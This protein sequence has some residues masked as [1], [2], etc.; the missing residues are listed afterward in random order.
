MVNDD[1]RVL[2]S[3]SFLSMIMYAEDKCPRFFQ[4]LGKCYGNK[5][6]DKAAVF[7]LIGYGNLFVSTYRYFIV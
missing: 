5:I 3:V 6:I 7:R 4:L 2:L 1:E